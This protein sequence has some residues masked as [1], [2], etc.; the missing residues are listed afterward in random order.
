MR[1]SARRCAALALAVSLATAG[2]CIWPG[3][4]ATVTPPSRP[5]E[6]V[7]VHL[8]RAARHAA[9]L[10]PCDGGRIVEYGFGEWGWYAENEEQWYDTMVRVTGPPTT[11]FMS[12]KLSAWI[13]SRA[14]RCVGTGAGGGGSGAGGSGS[15]AAPWLAP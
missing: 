14:L 1:D 5:E 8:V 13:A 2:L 11:P 12:L 4:V 7:T 15:A 3:C 6:P 9:L 10:L